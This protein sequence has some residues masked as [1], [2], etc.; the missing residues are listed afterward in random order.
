MKFGKVYSGCSPS[1]PTPK[2]NLEMIAVASGPKYA[3]LVPDCRHSGRPNPSRISV[4]NCSRKLATWDCWLLTKL[5]TERCSA[6]DREVT[7]FVRRE[8]GTKSAHKRFDCSKVADPP[9]PS[10]TTLLP[11]CRSPKPFPSR[12]SAGS[13][14]EN[15]RFEHQK[16]AWLISRPV[17]NGRSASNMSDCRW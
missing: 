12:A 11:Q 15:G 1:E 16:I 6:I 4:A 2:E 7:V 3:S 8:Y 17:W 10:A 9:E 5:R 13:I 14:L